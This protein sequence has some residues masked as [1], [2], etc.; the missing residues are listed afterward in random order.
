MSRLYCIESGMA[1]VSR[2]LGVTWIMLSLAANMLSFLFRILSILAMSI[3]SRCSLMTFFCSFLERELNH[4]N[5]SRIAMSVESLMNRESRRCNWME[6]PA[7]RRESLVCR[8]VGAS[9]S[10]T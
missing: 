3:G 10:S 4:I 5:E 8:L 1:Y 6:S 2:I 7:A 9:L